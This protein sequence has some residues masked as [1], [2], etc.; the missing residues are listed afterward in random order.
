MFYVYVHRK[1]DT[2][3]VFYVGKG[4][5]GRA[6]L[7]T[8]RT[9]YWR[10]VADKHG[11]VVEI[12]EYF[13]SEKL[14]FKHEIALISLHRLTGVQIVNLTFGGEGASGRVHSVATKEKMSRAH[15]GKK[16]SAEAIFKMSIAS[17]GRKQKPESI[18]KTAAA[19]RGRKR[20]AESI[21]KTAAGLAGKRLSDKHRASLRKAWEK[22]RSMP[23][24]H[25]TRARI[26]AAQRARIRRPWTDEEKRRASESKK[27]FVMPEESKRKIS[28]A[29]KR[30]F[31]ERRAAGFKR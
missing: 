21:A 3:E 5:G 16:M 24:S 9:E 19:N 23:I 17:K 1:A 22:R 31:A 14:A 18:A 20:S 7:R 13:E 12:L 11:H 30:K 26:S 27:G 2:G 10:R 15:T 6:S 29:L 8:G 4:T 25:E 28:E